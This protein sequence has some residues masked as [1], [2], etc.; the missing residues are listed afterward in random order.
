M[1]RIRN[2]LS[3]LKGGMLTRE[4]ASALASHA[5]SPDLA[6]RLME[7][8]TSRVEQHFDSL[9]VDEIVL[10][11][12]AALSEEWS[13]PERRLQI[14]PGEEVVQA[15][16]RHFGGEYVKPS[17]TVGI[18]REMQADELSPEIIEIIRTAIALAH[19]GDGSTHS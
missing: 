2:E 13:D 5:Q 6:K 8:M 9:H 18:A 1:K 19:E 10:A 15:V 14:A 11:E 16:Y 7:A 4:E 12:R 17:D 3:G